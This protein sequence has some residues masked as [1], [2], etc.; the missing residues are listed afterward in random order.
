[1]LPTPKRGRSSFTA[2]TIH[3]RL[4]YLHGA[5]SWAADQKLVGTVPRFPEVKVAKKKP[6]PVPAEMFERL[7]E[8]VSDSQTCAFLLCGWLAGMRRNEAAALEWEATDK[9]PNLD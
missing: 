5:L 4:G 3:V 1:K 9:A 7:L 6:Q 8:K 2:S